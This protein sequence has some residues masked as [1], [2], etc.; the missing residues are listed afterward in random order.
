MAYMWFIMAYSSL[1]VGFCRSDHV[2]LTC[3]VSLLIRPHEG[4]ETINLKSNT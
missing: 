1:V 2:E 3:R 4:G